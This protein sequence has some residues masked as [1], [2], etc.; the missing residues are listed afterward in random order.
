MTAIQLKRIA[1]LEAYCGPA[2][3]AILCS[4]YGLDVTQ[5]SIAEKANAV[6]HTEKYGMRIDQMALAIRKIAPH[7]TLLAKRNASLQDVDL[8]INTYNIAVGVEWQGIF[9]D[10]EE[11]PETPWDDPDDLGHYSVITGINLEDQKLLVQDPSDGYSEENREFD[12]ETFEKR[13]FD[14]NEVGEDA[15]EEAKIWMQDYHVLFLLAPKD[16]VFPEE[17]GLKKVRVAPTFRKK[18]ALEKAFT[19]FWK[20]TLDHVAPLL[21][22]LR[23]QNY[24]QRPDTGSTAPVSPTA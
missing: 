20:K 10:E 15:P 18:S 16:M 14:T 19:M 12:L 7:L 8:L 17:L 5:E 13:W 4:Q 23:L 22:K 24:G 11:N 1:Q 9:E 3:L 6:E 21:T 2:S